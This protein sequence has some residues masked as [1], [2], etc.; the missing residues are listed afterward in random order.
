MLIEV[1]DTLA[2]ASQKQTY[3]SSALQRTR[4]TK[5]DDLKIDVGRVRVLLYCISTHQQVPLYQVEE[6]QSRSII[7]FRKEK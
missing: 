3:A 6:N 1:L 7:I 5:G 4:E 2:Q